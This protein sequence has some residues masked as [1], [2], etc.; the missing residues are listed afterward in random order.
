MYILIVSASIYTAPEV[1]TCVYRHVCQ[2]SHNWKL[3]LAVVSAVAVD[4]VAVDAVV[5]AVAVD[6]VA[7]DAVVIAVAVDSVVS[8]CSWECSCNRWSCHRCSCQSSCSE[9][10]HLDLQ[11][12]VQLQ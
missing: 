12:L 7:V 3:A 2:S 11:L 9:H 10:K 4:A 1:A 8:R 5:S 6:T